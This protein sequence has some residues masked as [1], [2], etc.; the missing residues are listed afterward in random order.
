[1]GVEVPGQDKIIYQLR[2]HV[3][4]YL[5][6][7]TAEDEKNAIDNSTRIAIRTVSCKLVRMVTPAIK[8]KNGWFP[9]Y[10]SCG[11]IDLLLTLLVPLLGKASH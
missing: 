5:C 4:Y 6:L 2:K 3:I 7:D 10:L 9:L 8:D 11:C 1:V